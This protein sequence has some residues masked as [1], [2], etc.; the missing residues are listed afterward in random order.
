MERREYVDYNWIY[1]EQFFLLM[2][3]HFKGNQPLKSLLE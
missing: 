3:Y 1:M 2:E